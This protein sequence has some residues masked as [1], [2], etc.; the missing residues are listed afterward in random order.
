MLFS[1]KGGDLLEVI[2]TD[3]AFVAYIANV[4]EKLF[5]DYFD[6]LCTKGYHFADTSWESMLLY[7]DK[8]EINMRYS[9]DGA[10]VTT[11]RARIYTPEESAQAKQKIEKEIAKSNTITQDK[12]KTETA[13][14]E[15]K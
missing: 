11:L 12:P 15:K 1:A 13:K 9:Q 5:K 7:N 8:Y 4:D 3:N 6:L 10:T 2:N 14:T